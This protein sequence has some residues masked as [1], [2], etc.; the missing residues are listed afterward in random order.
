MYF[1]LFCQKHDFHFLVEKLMFNKKVCPSHPYDGGKRCFKVQASVGKKVCPKIII[2]LWLM[3]FFPIKMNLKNPWKSSFFMSISKSQ[4]TTTRH[5]NVFEKSV[6]VLYAYSDLNYPSKKFLFVMRLRWNLKNKYFQVLNPCLQT[7]KKLTKRQRKRKRKRKR[8]RENSD[9]PLFQIPSVFRMRLPV[10]C[11]G[12]TVIR[13]S[14][15]VH[16][17]FHLRSSVIASYTLTWATRHSLPS[18]TESAA[19][20]LHHAKNRKQKI[21]RAHL[22]PVFLFKRCQL[23]KSV[24]EN[25]AVLLK[26]TPTG[27]LPNGSSYPQKH[28]TVGTQTHNREP[29]GVISHQ[30]CMELQMKHHLS[31]AAMKDIMHFHE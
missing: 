30:S 24:S 21:H 1:Q 2:S 7:S 18:P 22:H 27:L 8:K 4:K 3:N 12:P 6:R 19:S 5:R 11:W 28:R 14:L 20:D 15:S 31:D 23:T 29:R 13:F 17:Q 26:T 25:V 10:N 16:P 9:F